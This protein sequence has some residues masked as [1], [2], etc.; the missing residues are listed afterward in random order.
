MRLAGLALVALVVCSAAW[1]TPRQV[2]AFDR[3]V[4]V[5]LENKSDGQVLG[6]PHAPAFNAFARNKSNSA[7]ELYDWIRRIFLS[8]REIELSLMLRS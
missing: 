2:P 6:D 3:V 8:F 4:V 1:S 7:S 5:V